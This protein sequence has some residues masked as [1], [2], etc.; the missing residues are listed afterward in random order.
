[1]IGGE[2]DRSGWQGIAPANVHIEQEPGITLDHD[3]AYSVKDV[4]KHRW[5]SPGK[6]MGIA[7]Q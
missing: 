4:R 5:V 2:Q 6:H 7:Y 3:A 1:V